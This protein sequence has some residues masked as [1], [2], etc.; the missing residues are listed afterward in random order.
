MS[1]ATAGA[2][3]SDPP[4]V[5]GVL[6]ALGRLGNG[7]GFVSGSAR[8]LGIALAG[9]AMMMLLMRSMLY[10]R[11]G[12]GVE[13]FLGWADDGAAGPSAALLELWRHCRFIWLAQTYM[14][15]D[16]FLF[17]PIYAAFFLKTGRVLAT[18]LDED[19]G[20]ESAAGRRWYALFWVP[21][22]ML[23]AADLLE[24]LIGLARTPGLGPFIGVGALA[25]GLVVLRY[26]GGLRDWQMRAHPLA[27]VIGI[28][29]L[30]GLMAWKYF[31]ADACAAADGAT[32]LGRLG[33]AANHGKD[34][35]VGVVLFVLAVGA[36]CWLFGV[37]LYFRTVVPGNQARLMLR[38]N[39]R[40]AIFDC[41]VR[42]RY[43]LVAL[44][45]L[46]GLT[47]VM[48]QSRDIIASTASF[49][50]R[51]F[52]MIQVD[53]GERRQRLRTPPSTGSAPRGCFWGP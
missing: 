2:T 43:V 36:I 12:W 46:A 32:W 45:L 3:D 25:L 38:A 53:W 50:P 18:A 33:C 14:A 52:T 27:L 6:V 26:L 29:V 10:V 37:V 51:F 48:D 30:A 42:S 7:I 35:L 16:S 20:N 4:P 47:V 31:L 22:L 15:L 17:V 44:A 19:A 5:P 24:N 11:T 23:V 34:V 39:L 41:L 8:L 40:T 9:A 49:V 28:G 21:V 1:S 13:D